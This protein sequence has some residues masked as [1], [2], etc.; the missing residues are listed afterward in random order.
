MFKFS[1]DWLTDYI[2]KNIP[3]KEILKILGSQGFEFQGE[4]K[5]GEDIITEIEVKA[6]RP[7]M[8]SH[9]G[10]AREVKAFCGKEIP[11]PTKADLKINNDSFPIK[12]RVNDGQICRRFS[13]IVIK[14]IDNTIPTPNYIKRR[15]EAL[16]IN[17]VNAVVDIA[18]YIML[19]MGQ[20]MHSYDVDK[21]NDNEIKVFKATD[22]SKIIILGNKEAEIKPGDIMISDSENILCVAGI[23]GTDKSTV[24]EKTKN[25]L[26]EGAVF[27]EINVRLT[28]RRLKISTPSSF[29]FER[30]V[31]I[32]YIL[33]ILLR[34]AKMITEICG[35]EILNEAFDFYPNKTTE[36]FLNLSVENT[37]RLLGTNL[38][39]DKI[40]DYL[41]KYNFKCTK[42]DENT[43]KIQVPSYRLDIK[44]EVDLIEE[45]ARIHGYDNIEAV[46]PTIQTNY[47][48]NEIWS[49][50]DKIRETLIGLKFS[51]TINYSFI[52]ENTMEI[53]GIEPGS[54]IY[55]DLTLQNPIAGAYSLM[56]PM[57]AFSLLNC[58]AYN[59]S[60]GN[61]NLGLFELGKIYFK[62]SAF[63]TGCREIDTCAFIMSGIRIPRGWGCEKD[64]KYNYYDL[65]NYIKIIFDNFGQNFELK[66]NNYK[67]FEE[68]SGYDIIVNGKIIGFIGE[69]NKQKLSKIQNVKLIK[70]K[71]F[72]CEFYIKDVHEK[73]KNIEFESKYPPVKRLYN[74]VHEKNITAAEIINVIKSSSEIIRVIT[75][76]DIYIDKNLG[77]SKHAVLYEINYCS[78][79]STLT[80]EEIEGI[81]NIFLKNLSE[82]FGAKLKD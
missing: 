11:A 27:D 20:P 36:K 50:M 61:S 77:E 67:F 33:D 54:A 28:S 16:G 42:I 34:C 80:S 43:L 22:E 24:T 40:I 69:L 10:I 48:R 1:F 30:G 7:D 49:K 53:Y 17:T 47:S 8:L 45:V 19:D 3:F 51:E 15:L 66:Q 60:I 63:D 23:I 78:K 4:Q 73:V 6:N 38:Q 57:L 81:E 56:R 52:P 18:N 44:Q 31:N 12:I 68:S 75:V 76:K 37:N 62:D 55:S 39:M 64:I 46:M 70:D 21:L 79:T 14:N 13:G 29:R 74:L 65:L 35:G 2:D 32:D 71:I 82:K 58:L 59:Y 5:F 41:E 9:M 25:V 72:Y 26:L